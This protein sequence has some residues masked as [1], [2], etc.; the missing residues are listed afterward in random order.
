MTCSNNR[1][2]LC[3]VNAFDRLSYGKPEDKGGSSS[4]RCSRGEPSTS[5]DPASDYE[6]PTDDSAAAPSTTKDPKTKDNAGVAGSSSSVESH[7]FPHVSDPLRHRNRQS[8]VQM[9]AH[10][11]CQLIQT[12]IDFRLPVTVIVSLSTKVEKYVLLF[13]LLRLRYFLKTLLC[14]KRQHVKME[15]DSC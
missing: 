2:F 13:H 10:R 8:V 5:C 12:P 11:Q 15:V 4:S 14:T 7:L 3:Q 9:P 1:L 6:V